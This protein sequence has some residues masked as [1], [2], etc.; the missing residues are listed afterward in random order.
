MPEIRIAEFDND[1]YIFL[2]AD[3]G[4]VEKIENAINEFKPASIVNFA[5]EA[6]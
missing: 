5:A 1:R 3:I 4:N 6:M 2:K